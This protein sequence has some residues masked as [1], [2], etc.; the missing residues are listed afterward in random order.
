MIVAN[1][2]LVLVDVEKEILCWFWCQMISGGILYY[3]GCQTGR[4]YMMVKRLNLR[5][6]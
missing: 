3:F 4:A 1:I 6:C 5:K 2:Y